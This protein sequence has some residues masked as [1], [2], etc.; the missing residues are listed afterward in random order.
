MKI[1]RYSIISVVLL[2]LTIIL[3]DLH[4]TK[5][6]LVISPNNFVGK[7]IPYS[8]SSVVDGNGGSSIINID[9]VNDGGLY[10]S[11]TLNS[12]FNYYYAGVCISLEN[13][14]DLNHYK[15]V[16]GDIEF[17]SNCSSRFFI[18][19]FEDGISKERDL[20]TWRHLKQFI[21]INSKSLFRANLEQFITP[22]WW[23]DTY[24]KTEKSVT[25]T[26]LSSVL[27]FKVETG[28]GEEIGVRRS[29][30]VG[31][32]T[33]Y[34]PVPEA[35]RAVQ[36]ILLIVAF[37]VLA[38]ALGI[39]K[40]VS[41]GKYR[42]IVLGNLFD[43]ELE[44]IVNFIGEN[45]QNSSLS[46]NSVAEAIALHPDKVAALLKQGYGQTFKQ[47]LNMLRLTESQRLLRSTD[48]QISEIAAVVG[49]NSVT[50]FNRLFKQTYSCTPREYRG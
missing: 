19:T 2:I 40:R 33:F 15:M 46:L 11:Y 47:Y 44:K 31:D 22:Q 39:F 21:P 34:N 38:F 30:R 3:L 9:S 29:V 27:G 5:D 1:N 16:K 13:R 6:R 36:L 42:P 18:L 41:I 4:Y 45:Y 8:D 7:L 24:H 14:V 37:I 25:E 23:Y 10:Y 28:E 43:E 32:I 17:N 26:P 49:Y 48:R 20:T 35:I 12:K 50:H